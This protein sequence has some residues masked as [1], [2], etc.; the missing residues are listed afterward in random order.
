MPS[1][2][3]YPP[4]ARLRPLPALQR[5]GLRLLDMV[6]PPTCP[7]CGTIT[8]TPHALCS[9]CWTQIHF[10]APPLCEQC[11]LPFEFEAVAGSVCGACA[12]GEQPYERLRS[13]I[14][15]DDGSRRLILAFKNGDRTEAARTFAPWMTAAG[16][17]LLAQADMLAPVPLHWTRLFARRYNQAALLAYAVARPAGRRVVP[18]LLVRRKRTPRLGKSG[19]TARAATVRGV[20]EVAAGRRAELEGRRVLLIDDVYTTGS[21]TGSC[22]R[23]LLR[24]GAAAVDVLTLAR[25]VRP[26]MPVVLRPRSWPVAPSEPAEETL[27]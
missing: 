3:P 11:G 23:V 22:A 8:N 26:A 27:A 19:R 15:Y 12:G 17:E 18:D 2:L 14:A 9:P 16:E 21:T 1:I 25:V 10:I 7:A 20:F 5:L 6:L 24:A 4:V 13:A